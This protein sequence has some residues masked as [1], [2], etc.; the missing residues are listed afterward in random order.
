MV[1]LAVKAKMQI[2]AAGNKQRHRRFALGFTLL[3][4]L[5]VISIMAMVTTGISLAMKDSSTTQLEREAQR[6]VAL[7]ESARSQSRSSGIPVRWHVADTAFKFDGIAPNSL[8]TQWLGNSVLVAP[9]SQLLL[10]PEP[11]IGAQSII[12]VNAQKPEQ[13]LRIATDGLHPF[14]IQDLNAALP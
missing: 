3:E 5:I 8:P 7:L 13:A 1:T 9:Q 12:L 10:G 2:L 14:S 4:L 11:L 6:L